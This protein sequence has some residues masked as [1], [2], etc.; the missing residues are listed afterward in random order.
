MTDHVQLTFRHIH[1]FCD[2]LSQPTAPFREQHVQRW[3]GERLGA[4]GVP[5]F[6]D[7]DGN[8]VGGVASDAEYRR[9]LAARSQRPLPLF[10]AHMDHPGFMGLQWADDRHL[11]AR[12][13]GGSPTKHL[14]GAK[15]WIAD[16]AGYWGE[17]VVDRHDIAKHGFGL[18]SVTLKLT[19]W[20]RERRRPA[21]KRL[22]GGFGFRAPVWR[23]GNVL[24][25]KA[26][27]DLTG[28]FCALETL[29]AN[30]RAKSSP[31]VALFT[32]AEE[33]GFVGAIAHFERYRLRT[34]KRDL[35]AVSL[36]ASRTL[37]G[38]IVGNGPIVRLGD[39]RTVFN[40][41]GSQFLTRLA[42]KTL[43]PHFQRRIMDGGACEG[44]AATAYGIRT[45]AMSVPLGN[46]HNQGFEGGPDCAKLNGPAP[47]FVHMNDV[48]GMLAL[49]VQVAKHAAQVAADPWRETRA[50]LV[51]NY[52]NLKRFL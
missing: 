18:E 25:T 43:G 5:F 9:L 26:A 51:K 46:Y 10:I 6:A 42:E 21:A 27:D 8:I 11:K 44:T 39:R 30:K 40:P 47:E 20:P 41:D 12:W 45:I 24:Y 28:V 15:M 38:A 16:D 32:R 13:F 3:L 50:R 14:R 48:A 23:Q 7:A 1:S 2:L 52:K 31:V 35:L 36:E 49:C 17:A 37:P 34:S 22:F 33:V 4:A 19:K 29:I